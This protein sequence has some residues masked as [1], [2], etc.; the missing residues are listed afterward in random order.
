MVWYPSIDDVIDMNINALDLSGDKHPHKILG[1]HER[2]QAIIDKV[3]SEESKGLA[4]QAALLMKELAKFVNEVNIEE[5]KEW[6][7]HGTSEE[8]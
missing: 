1:S 7:E 8:S 2:I 3:K 4:Y 6:I 5:V